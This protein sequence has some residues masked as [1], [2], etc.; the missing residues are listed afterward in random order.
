MW[1]QAQVVIFSPRDFLFNIGEII[2]F[3]IRIHPRR[4]RYRRRPDADGYLRRCFVAVTVSCRSDI[5]T[6]GKFAGAVGI[7]NHS[8]LCP[9]L[10]YNGYNHL[11]RVVDLADFGAIVRVENAVS[12]R[13]VIA[14]DRIPPKAVAVC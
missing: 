2:R 8:Q 7:E 3:L 1:E 12:V 6:A 9:R 5:Y 13:P 14:C 11:C 4:R 10:V